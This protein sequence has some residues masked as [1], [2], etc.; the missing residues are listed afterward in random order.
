MTAHTVDRDIVIPLTTVNNPD[1]A[2][3]TP[4]GGRGSLSSAKLPLP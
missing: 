1:L 3:A 4:V 2:G